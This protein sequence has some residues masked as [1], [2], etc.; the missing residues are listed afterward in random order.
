M[1]NPEDDY[2]YIPLY[3]SQAPSNVRF[4]FPHI[5]SIFMELSTNVTYHLHDIVRLSNNVSMPTPCFQYFD[6]ELY[7]KLLRSPN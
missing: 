2:T 3:K 6:I 4:A 5:G 1:D 7:K